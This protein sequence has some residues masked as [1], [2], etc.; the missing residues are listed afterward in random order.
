MYLL[1]YKIYHIA[2]SIPANFITLADKR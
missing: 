2:V 1:I